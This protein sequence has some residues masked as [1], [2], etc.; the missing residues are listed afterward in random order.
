MGIVTESSLRAM[1]PSGIPNPFTL[2]SNGK[3]TPAAADFLRSR[4]IKVIILDEKEVQR[5]RQAFPLI[6]VGVSNRHVHLSQHHVEQLFGAGT[7]LTPDRPL[8]Q[9]GQYA[10]LE[11][12]TLRTAKSEI[13]GVRV[14]GPARKETQVEISRTDGFQLG[15]HAP[16]RLSGDTANTPGITLIGPAGQVQLAHGVIV[17][18]CHVHMSPA[19]AAVF[20]VKSGDVMTLRTLHTQERPLIFPSVAVRVDERY[21]LDFHIDMDEANAAGLHTGNHVQYI[22]EGQGGGSVGPD[23]DGRA[24]GA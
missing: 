11:K 8:S 14:L 17:A 16:L 13:R 3:L 6:P 9:P 7:S 12:V 20:Q 24:A 1:L 21:V 22:P 18:K 4:G 10:A 2:T 19:D 23:T 5:T 15:L